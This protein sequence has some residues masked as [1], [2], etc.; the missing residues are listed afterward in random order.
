[1]VT[2]EELLEACGSGAVERVEVAPPLP[3]LPREGQFLQAL[4]PGPLPPS[5]DEAEEVV[6]RA[7]L[8]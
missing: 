8:L 3:P 7:S 4:S 2:W 5:G 6:R 1:M